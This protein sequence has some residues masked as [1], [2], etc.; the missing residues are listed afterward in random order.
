VVLALLLATSLV[1]VLCGFSIA[2]VVLF[3]PLGAAVLEPD[4]HLQQTNKQT[5][6][7]EVL[8]EGKL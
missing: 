4:L 8:T 1:L 7:P 6:R 2:D 3:L 5:L